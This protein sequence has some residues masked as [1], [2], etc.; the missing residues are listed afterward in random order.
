MLLVL[1]DPGD[2]HFMGPCE[3]PAGSGGI[4]GHIA[5]TFWPFPENVQRLEATARRAAPARRCELIS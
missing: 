4:S 3:G 2:E 1:G 5:I